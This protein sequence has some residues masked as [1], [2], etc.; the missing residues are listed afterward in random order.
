LDAIQRLED[1]SDRKTKLSHEI[2][3]LAEMFQDDMYKL[4]YHIMDGLRIPFWNLVEQWKYRKR[5]IELVDYLLDN[6]KR[7][8]Q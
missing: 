8:T 4:Q 3:D 5:S 6:G 2:V 1:E 7:Y